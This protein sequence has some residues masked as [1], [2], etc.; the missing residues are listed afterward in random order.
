[1]LQET[2]LI[3]NCAFCRVS[4]YLF[5]SDYFSYHIP[6]P[7]PSID[8]L[9]YIP[10]WRF[11]G[12]S[13]TS[14]TQKTTQRVID[15]SILAADCSFA[16][17]S[18]GFRPQVLALQF[19]SPDTDGGFP[20]IPVAFDKVFSELAANAMI[21]TSSST[22]QIQQSFIGENISLIYAPFYRRDSVVFDAVLNKPL[23]HPYIELTE[24]SPGSDMNRFDNLKFIPNL[25]PYCG[26][27][28]KG[29][30]DSVVLI[31][32]NC[33]SAWA[34][35]EEGFNKVDFSV[36]L[37]SDCNALYLPF[38]RMKAKVTGPFSLKTSAD[39]I[40]FSNLPKVIK[41]TDKEKQL[42]FWAPA[43]KI[44]PHLF[45]R[46]S[47]QLTVFQPETE[48]HSNLSN[49]TLFPVRLKAAEASNGI[50]ITLAELIT[51]KRKRF[52]QL[53]E[54]EVSL[55]EKLLVFI[56][57]SF[58]GNEIVENSMKISLFRTA[59]SMGRHI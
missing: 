42:Y 45:L 4:L 17:P 26:W 58:Q 44:A 11:K 22:A 10:Y 9:F 55:Q 29:A 23:K 56:G 49:K 41:A 6:V 7:D 32:Q 8:G 16:K 2:D 59:L 13:F 43:F 25:C 30:R 1:M 37:S 57:F 40:R 21:L 12:M 14:R 33:E 31:C 46:L 3:L 20:L 27:G 18:L 51:D 52:P 24:P 50:V 15:T 34:A 5:T 36:N 47:R 35:T 28:L 53:S 54:T 48:E 19:V 38:W 39:L